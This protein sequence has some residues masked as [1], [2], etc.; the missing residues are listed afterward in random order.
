MDTK[1][2]PLKHP[3]YWYLSAVAIFKDEARNLDEWL[4]F[5]VSE[6]IEHVLLYDH[7]S[8][9]D[10]KAVLQPW[11]DAGIVEL[12]DWPV[13][14]KN[15]AQENAYI[16]AL[17]RLRGRSRWAA[18]I[19][20]DEFLFS[21]SGRALPD[22]LHRY[23]AHAGVV[24]NWQCYGTSGHS[25]RPAGLTIETYT[26][27]ARTG[28][29]RNRRVKTIVDPL[30]AIEPDSPHLFRVQPG[31]A[32]VTE[33]FK[34]V[35]LVRS[36]NGRRRMRHLAAW[37]P[38]LPFDPYS[39]T[40]PL[41]EQVSVSDLRINHYV[42][43]SKEDVSLK[44]KDRSTMMASDRRS[45]SRYHDRNEVEDPIL[46]SKAV[47]VREIIARVRVADPLKIQMGG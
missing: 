6:G 28:W 8:T 25:T 27:R 13:A 46:A 12:I 47:R 17:R 26:R 15:G 7:F 42:T 43:R 24:V 30:A 16:D 35:E 33:D 10:S 4:A 41:P 38:Y 29:A 45:Y 23:E 21:P 39:V 11:I 14:W 2:H 36:K 44:Y 34:P 3:P 5:G 37:L 32:L 9:D 18:F 1:I 20:V 31:E 40:R 22:V 19:D